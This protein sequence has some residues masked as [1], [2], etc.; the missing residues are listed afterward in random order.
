MIQVWNAYNAST[1][2]MRKLRAFSPYHSY[3]FVYLFS[4]YLLFTYFIVFFVSIQYILS[5]IDNCI[6]YGEDA[7]VKIRDF[8][9]EDEWVIFRSLSNIISWLAVNIRI[10]CFVFWFYL[11]ANHFSTCRRASTSASICWNY[12]IFYLIWTYTDCRLKK[13]FGLHV[14][15][16]HDL[17]EWKCWGLTY[18][19][20]LTTDVEIS[21]HRKRK[22][23]YA[24]WIS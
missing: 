1:S 19:T 13:M 15:F 11:V 7:D 14:S 10:V 3:V 23:V 17:L 21:Q 5:T 16:Q 9:P 24:S 6:Q 4:F 12:V 20:T 22:R 8:D 18:L 2:V